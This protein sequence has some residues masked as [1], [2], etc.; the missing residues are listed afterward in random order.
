MQS[1]HYRRSNKLQWQAS[2]TVKVTVLINFAAEQFE[3]ACCYYAQIW[4]TAHVANVLR[5]QVSAASSELQ[6]CRI[7]YYCDAVAVC[8]DWS[9]G[10]SPHLSDG[11]PPRRH[12]N[13]EPD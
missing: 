7:N 4:L 3:S 9:G 5:T 12:N 11:L 6:S 2:A 13:T 8:E 1:H 10:F